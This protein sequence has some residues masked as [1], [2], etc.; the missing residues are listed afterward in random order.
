M[1]RDK[2][3]MMMMFIKG[4]WV[5]LAIFVKRSDNTEIIRGLEETTFLTKK[6]ITADYEFLFCL[7]WKKKDK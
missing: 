4:E 5:V 6:K 1:I 2:W 3:M 7:F